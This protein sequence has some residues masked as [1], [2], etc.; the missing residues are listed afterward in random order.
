MS[1]AHFGSVNTPVYRTSTILQPDVASLKSHNTTYVYGRRGTPTTRSFED[2]VSA[3]EGAARTVSLPSGLSAIT[4]AI[5][6][7]CRAG[8][9]LLM[10]DSCYGPTRLFCDGV[11]KR[12][13]V[14]TTYYD[15]LI[16]D[17]VAALFRPNTRAVYCESPGSLT[18]EVQDVPVIAAAAHAR[19]ASVLMDNT[20]GTPLYFPALARGVDLSI[21]AATKYICG[22][23]DT[24]MGTVSANESHAKRLSNFVADLGLYASGDDCFL[25][26]RGLRTLAVR[27]KRHH[28]TALTLTHWLLKR[29]EVS[30][31]L[32]PALESD[33]GHALWKRDFLGACGLFGVVLKPAREKSVAAMIDGMRHFGIGYSW[34]G[35]ES[36]IIPAEFERTACKFEAEG[37]V[38]RIHAGLEDPDDLLA[39]L[40]AG[41]TRLNAP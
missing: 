6:S 35:Y 40:E 18:F 8:D 5:M 21:H 12:F 27:L 17:G 25:A 9:H 31:V 34:G 37:P 23:S 13:G 7:V 36:L 20:W 26:L 1:A 22:H 19:N 14:E 2:A 28:Q 32:Y 39:D 29:P 15:P 16:G 3:L 38:I 10:V 24:M 30:R 41:F 4:V 11:L 33:P